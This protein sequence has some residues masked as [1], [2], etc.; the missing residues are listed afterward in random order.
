[1]Q[2]WSGFWLDGANACLQTL[3]DAKPETRARVT[4][5]V[6]ILTRENVVAVLTSLGVPKEFDVLSVDI[7]HNTYHIWE[8]T[9][10]WCPRVVVV[11][12][13]ALVPPHL[14]WKVSYAPSI[15]WDRTHN[16]G[17]S[18]KSLELLGRGLGY[19]LVGC[20]L[21]GTNAFFV[22]ND[23]IGSRFAERFTAEQ[24]YQPYRPWLSSG[25]F[26]RTRILE[27]CFPISPVVKHL[28]TNMTGD[29]CMT[30]HSTAVFRLP[31]W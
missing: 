1:M 24:H 16:F 15:G 9:K 4:C 6:E 7:D 10:Q 22:R 11:E 21:S 17:A 19:S 30:L 27:D 3:A 5:H 14:D 12:Y 8:A 25:H 20:D 18:L 31:I 28:A 13:N 29:G 2:G 26:L 23:L